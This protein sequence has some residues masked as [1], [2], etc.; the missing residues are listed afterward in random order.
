MPTPRL[1][2]LSPIHRASR[3]IGISLARRMGALGLPAQEAHVLSYLRSYAPC[4]IS[5]LHRVLGLKRS[6][7]TS[8]LDRLEERAIVR[9]EPCTRDR[10]S[11]QLHLTDAG[12]S[13]ADRV[14]EPLEELDGSILAEVSAGDVRG[15][16]RVL[17]AIARVTGVEVRTEEER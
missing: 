4:P 9:R 1:R 6:T 2:F 10:R 15:F 13:L 7:L 3:Q 8:M 12:R 14:Q 16:E 5:E 17:A 11:F